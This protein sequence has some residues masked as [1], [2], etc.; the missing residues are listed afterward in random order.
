MRLWTLIT[1]QFIYIC[2]LVLLTYPELVYAGA[3]GTS[4]KRSEGN[5]ILALLILPI[6]LGMMTFKKLMK[7]YAQRAAM[8]VIKK[9]QKRDE[10]W[11]IKR[12]RTRVEE[13]FKSLQELWS[14]NDIEGSQAYLHPH[15]AEVYLKKLRLYELRGEFNKIS[16]IDINN[17]SIVMAKDFQ[18]PDQD[19]F[20][21]HIEGTMCDNFYDDIG[22]HLRTNGD[23][24]G[25]SV[26]EINEYWYY[27]RLDEKWLLV[28]ICQ[29]DSINH[30]D[31]SIDSHSIEEKNLSESKQKEELAKATQKARN[32]QEQTYYL[33]LLA[34]FLVTLSGYIVYC[35]FFDSILDFI[36]FYR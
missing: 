32:S 11:N 7:N 21:A 14:N 13:S 5:I 20:V 6:V 33:A 1:Q 24:K 27:R 10:I 23:K 12:I 17:I 19:L 36:M 9:A 3:G 26:R 8:K 35:F 2:S 22:F 16:E 29:N 30:S 15:Y 4:G 34:G 25:S 18:D 31:I 28:G